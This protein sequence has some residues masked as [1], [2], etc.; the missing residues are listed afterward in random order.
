LVAFISISPAGAAVP[1]TGA[2]ILWDKF[3]V[4]HVSGKNNEGPQVS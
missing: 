2:E 1:S 3:G 4:A